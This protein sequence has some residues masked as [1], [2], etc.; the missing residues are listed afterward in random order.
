MPDGFTCDAEADLFNI[1]LDLRAAIF[2]FL[3][4]LELPHLLDVFARV[5]RECAHL[6]AHAVR[7]DFQICGVGCNDILLIGRG[8]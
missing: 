7:R 2:T 5:R 1:V 8:F 4:F 3:G 6:A